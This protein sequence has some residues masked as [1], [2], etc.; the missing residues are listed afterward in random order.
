MDEAKNPACAALMTLTLFILAPRDENEIRLY[1]VILMYVLHYVM[2]VCGGGLVRMMSRVLG[3][4]FHCKTEY[5]T[6]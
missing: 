6:I 1:I 2:S 4:L 5:S 3:W